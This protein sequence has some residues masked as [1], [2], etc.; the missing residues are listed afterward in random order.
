MY[1]EGFP[2]ER[3]QVVYGDG[4]SVV[5][6]ESLETCLR[7][8][9]SGYPLNNTVFHGI[10]SHDTSVTD[11]EVLQLIA[12][13]VGATVDPIDGEPLHVVLYN[14]FWQ[15]YRYVN[16]DLPC[17]HAHAHNNLSS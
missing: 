15:E 16:Y 12:S 10:A 2:D 6:K 4:D 13:I 1:G 8:T 5:N 11:I 14:A 17:M 7:W 3:P 9:D